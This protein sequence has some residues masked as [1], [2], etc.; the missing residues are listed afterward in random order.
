MKH[1]DRETSSYTEPFVLLKVDPKVSI[2]KVG[3]SDKNFHFVAPQ[4]LNT[5]RFRL[6]TLIHNSLQTAACD[7]LMSGV[8]VNTFCEP[9]QLTFASPEKHRLRT[10]WVNELPELPEELEAVKEAFHTE[11]NSEDKLSSVLSFWSFCYLKM[12]VTEVLFF[13]PTLSEV[14]VTTGRAARWGIGLRPNL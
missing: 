8:A 3:V 10:K 11:V 14:L 12:H 7:S 13:F 2:I 1:D 9:Q 4:T 6:S 5:E